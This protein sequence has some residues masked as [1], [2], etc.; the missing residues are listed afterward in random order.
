MPATGGTIADSVLIDYQDNL[1]AQDKTML[2]DLVVTEAGEQPCMTLTFFDAKCR[3]HHFNGVYHKV[4]FGFSA[5]GSGTIAEVQISGPS[6]VTF[7][8]GTLVGPYPPYQSYPVDIRMYGAPGGQTICLTLTAVFTDGTVCSDEMCFQTPICQEPGPGDVN[9]DFKVD[10]TDLLA[11][12]ERWGDQCDDDDDCTADQ[13]GDGVVGI[14][15]LLIVLENW[16]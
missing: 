5:M 11:V 8:P 14:S 3:Y 16:S 9:Y 6:G 13:D 7:N 2:G 15:D 10:I 4:E 12:I 1:A